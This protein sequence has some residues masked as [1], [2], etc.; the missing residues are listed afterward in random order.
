MNSELTFLNNIKEYYSDSTDL[1]KR[2]NVHKNFSKIRV[3]WDAWVLDKLPNEE[4]INKVLDLGCGEGRFIKYLLQK[5]LGNYYSGY[6]LSKSNIQTASEQTIENKEKVKYEVADVEVIDYE[7]N[8]YDLI[9]CNHMLWHIKDKEKFLKRLSNSMTLQGVFIATTNS[10]DYMHQLYDLH[11]NF[12]KSLKFPEYT[13][14]NP[15]RC[16]GFNLEEGESVLS[17]YFSNVT[18]YTLDNELLFESPEPFLDYYLIYLKS[19]IYLYKDIPVNM[20]EKLFKSVKE[21]VI[22]EIREN[23]IFKVQTKSGMF[24]GNKNINSAK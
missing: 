18:G 9:M 19:Q 8:S 12:M 4:N 22:N 13:T 7:S 21:Y 11:F 6:D 14:G 3:M 16:T 24:I 15:E 23:K 10:S 20:W 5:S 1:M 2:I 17:K